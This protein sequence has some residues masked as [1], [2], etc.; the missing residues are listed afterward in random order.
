MLRTLLF[1]KIFYLVKTRLELLCWSAALIL[2]FLMPVNIGEQS[3]CV[4]RFIGFNSCPGCGLGHAI[5]SV[6][7]LQFGQSFHEHI[8][9]IPA[10]L[11]ILNRIK[12]LS[13]SKKIIA[14]EI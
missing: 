4:F 2:L 14:Y 7:H 12:H 10:V 6:L 1:N 3:L 5:H 11:I 13:F 9:G 8:F